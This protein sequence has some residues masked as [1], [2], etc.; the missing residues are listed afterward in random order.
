MAVRLET[1]ELIQEADELTKRNAQLRCQILEKQKKI[2]SLEIESAT[3]SQTLELLH[4]EFDTLQ[5][6]VKEE[7]IYYEKVAKEMNS[8]LQGQQDWINSHKLEKTSSAISVKDIGEKLLDHSGG[9]LSS[10]LP[11]A[12]EMTRAKQGLELIQVDS[13]SAKLDELKLKQRIAQF[14]LKT[15]GFPCEIK[16]AETK[17]LE[18]E[19]Q[20]LLTDKGGELE[21]LQSLQERIGLFLSSD[22]DLSSRLS[23][24]AKPDVGLE[25]DEWVWAGLAKAQIWPVPPSSVTS[26]PI[27]I[28]NGSFKIRILIVSSND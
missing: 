6:K 23:S 18:E 8:N 7:R 12:E 2:S 26:S 21:Y 13:A 27:A 24:G 25:E 17:I 9:S 28:C 19:H 20:A 4:K 16:T 3:L 5:E 1:K 15:E 10:E 11:S 22:L 14:Q